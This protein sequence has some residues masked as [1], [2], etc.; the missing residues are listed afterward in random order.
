MRALTIAAAQLGPIQRSHSRAD[1]VDR[2]IGLMRTAKARGADLIVYPEL[3]LT[4]F[5]PRWFIEDPV[6][7]DT[8][9]EREVPGPETA[10]LFAE[11]KRLGIGFHLGYAEKTADGHRFN[12]AIL[13]EKTGEIVGKYRKI[14][15]PG[16]AENEPWRAFQ[17]LEKR[18]F[19]PGNLGF[20][21]FDAFGGR[22]GIAICNDRRWSETYRVMGLQGSEVILIGFNTPIHNPPFPE[23]DRLSWHH[24][25]I[26]MQAGAYQNASF[27]VGVAKAGVEEGVHHMGGSQIIAPSGETIAAATTED[28]ELVISTCDLDQC[29]SYRE[30]VFAFERHREPGSYA[31]ITG[32]RGVASP[33]RAIEIDPALGRDPE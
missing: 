21:V 25:S 29:R 28:D 3:A 31:L 8:F 26:V 32:T 23:H 1:V 17:H 22:I 10:A 5:F 20:R 11:A 15:L 7:L 9:Y 4:T 13:V 16:H 27:V 19:E 18:Y 12:T 14:H 24:N 30:S 2:L 33:E 6:E